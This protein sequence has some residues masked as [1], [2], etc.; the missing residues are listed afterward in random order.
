[1]KLLSS[2]HVG[3]FGRKNDSI[4]NLRNASGNRSGKHGGYGN[5]RKPSENGVELEP[6]AGKGIESIN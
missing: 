3:D 2:Y 5:D 4:D 1:M 6:R